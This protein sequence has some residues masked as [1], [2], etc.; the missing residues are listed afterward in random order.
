MSE[1]SKSAAPDDGQQLRAAMAQ[2][3]AAHALTVALKMIERGVEDDITRQDLAEPLLDMLMV[4][5]DTATLPSAQ[6]G[7]EI[8]TGEKFLRLLTGERVTA[9]GGVVD[10][11]VVHIIKLGD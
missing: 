7:V 4:V 2:L 9:A 1:P 11:E 10:G 3:D 5:S 6:P 8:E